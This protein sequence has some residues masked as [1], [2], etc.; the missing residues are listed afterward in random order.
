LKSNEQIRFSAA[1]DPLN[2]ARGSTSKGREGRG[3]E[4]RVEEGNGRSSMEGGR[5]H[6]QCST[7]LFI[8]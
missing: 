3:R 8:P 1:P 7:K 6:D 2:P 4:G 5:G